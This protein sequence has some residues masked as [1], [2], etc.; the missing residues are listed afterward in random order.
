[1]KSNFKYKWS[2]LFAAKR[3]N[4]NYGIIKLTP[5]EQQELLDDSDNH[6]NNLLNDL[7]LSQEEV[8]SSPIR[9][10][11]VSIENIKQ[12]FTKHGIE[13]KQPF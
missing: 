11:G 5:V 1:M 6:N 10:N 8:I 12:I 2:R 9:F 13:Y 3:V 7:L 4:T